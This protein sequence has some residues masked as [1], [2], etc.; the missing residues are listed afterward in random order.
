MAETISGIAQTLIPAVSSIAQLVL[1]LLA[2]ILVPVSKVISFI[3]KT[4]SAIIKPITKLFGA[5]YEEIPKISDNVANIEENV[6][7]QDLKEMTLGYATYESWKNGIIGKS[8]SDLGEKLDR[9]N[10]NTYKSAVTSEEAANL[11]V[12]A[13]T[14]IS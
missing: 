6:V 2:K 12:A 3:A 11:A 10:S 7:K 4:I 5:T 14:V 8:I 1:P 9:I 13:R